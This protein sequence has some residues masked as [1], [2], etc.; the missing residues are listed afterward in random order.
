MTMEKWHAGLLALA[1]KKEALPFEIGDFLQRHVPGVGEWGEHDGAYK[2]IREAA[3]Y[4][5]QNGVELAMKSLAQYREVSAKFPHN[6]RHTGVC[7]QAHVNAKTPDNLDAIVS[8]APKGQRITTT[9]VRGVMRAWENRHRHAVV[10][11]SDRFAGPSN[12][13]KAPALDPNEVALLGVEANTVSL[14]LKAA[15]LADDATANLEGVLPKIGDG[16]RAELHEAAM[17]AANKWI[18]F[19]KRVGSTKSRRGGLSVVA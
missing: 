11:A 4:L 3:E 7:W 1:R 15:V 14:A 12:K 16:A 9:Y 8:G 10:P 6:R 19:A 18:E 5:E 13:Y 2:K 17:A